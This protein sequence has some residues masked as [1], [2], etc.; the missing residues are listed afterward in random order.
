[1]VVGGWQEL[2]F[3]DDIYDT[4]ETKTLFEGAISQGS[5]VSVKDI[6]KYTL[7]FLSLSSNSGNE[8]LSLLSRAVVIRGNSDYSV[9]SVI[10]APYDN[11]SWLNSLKCSIDEDSFFYLNGPHLFA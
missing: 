7:L 10:G 6:H 2:V 3:D 11:F 5:A 1:M 4:V 8:D 9:L